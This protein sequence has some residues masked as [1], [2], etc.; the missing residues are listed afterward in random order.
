MKKIN[1][2]GFTLVEVIAVVAIITILSIILIPN[3]TKLINKEKN[4]A[5]DSIEKTILIAAKSF[6]TDNKQNI[7]YDSSNNITEIDNEVTANVNV[8]SV[9]LNRGY[10]SATYNSNG[11]E[12]II[13][14][15]DKSQCVS[16]DAYVKVTP[17]KV[18]NKVKGFEYKLEN[19]SFKACSSL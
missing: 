12:G 1:N 19:Y 5:R 3:V 13:N 2:K 17:K 7:K 6:V 16:K 4:E 11:K 10:I 8:Y 9:L 18:G 14:P 15:A